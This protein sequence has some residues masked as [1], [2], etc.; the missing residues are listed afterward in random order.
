MPL[1]VAQEAMA[2][3]IKSQNMPRYP[4]GKKLLENSEIRTRSNQRIMIKTRQGDV[5]VANQNARI[6]LVKPGFFSQLFGKIFY[7]ITPRRDSRVSVN[8]ATATI[9]IRGTTFIIDSSQAN[10]QAQRVALLKGKLQ[11][12]ANNDE[13]F[14]L[15]Q[16]REMNEFERYKRQILGEFDAY[17]QQMMQQFVAYRASIDLQAGDALA[18]DGNKVVRQPMDDNTTREFAEFERY[19][20]D[21]LP[22]SDGD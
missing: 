21:A 14:A 19:I 11:I 9:G 1:A 10:T 15:Y 4:V 8:T 18:F 13:E 20:A 16:Q 6:K 5:L 3:V 12:D 7:F 17:K 2:R 22:A